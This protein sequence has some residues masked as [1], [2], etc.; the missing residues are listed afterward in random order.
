MT[1]KKENFNYCFWHSDCQNLQKAIKGLGTDED[2]LIYTLGNRSNDQRLQIR[3]K[4]KIM[5]GK[6]RN[7]SH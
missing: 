1:E 7:S 4:Y 3:D 5:Y 6:V 2:M